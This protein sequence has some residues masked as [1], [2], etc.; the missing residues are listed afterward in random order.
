MKKVAGLI[1]VILIFCSLVVSVNAEE[2]NGA[3]LFTIDLPEDFQQNE[4]SSS[5]FSFENADGDT[6]TVIYNDN[7]QEGNIFSPA[8]MGKKAIEEYKNTIIQETETIMKDQL[9]GL[10]LKYLDCEKIKHK[11]GK[12]ALVSHIET[13]IEMNGRKGVYYQTIYEFGGANYKYSFTFTTTDKEK[14]N[15]LNATFDTINIFE[16]ETE[17]NID[18]FKAFAV[19]ATV[20]LLLIIGIVRFIRTPEKREKGKL[21]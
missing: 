21:K 19:A 4:A 15:S 5:D 8:D 16:S 18:R 11:N 1:L 20:V 2:F 3:D 9:D 10:N 17:T 6:V 12:T 14:S 13:T 7:K